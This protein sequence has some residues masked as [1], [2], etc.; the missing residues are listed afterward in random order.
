MSFRPSAWSPRRAAALRFGVE[1]DKAMK[2]RGVGRPRL[3]EHLGMKSHSIIAHWRSGRGLPRIDAAIQL[4]SVLDCPKLVDIVKSVVD[5][6]C[7]TCGKP[8]THTG[9][10]PRRYCSDRCRDIRGKMRAGQPLRQ[11]ADIAEQR[12]A[13]YQIAVNGYCRS[14]EPQGQCREP[15]CPLR[16]VSPLPIIIDL[17]PGRTR[18][19]VQPSRM[20]RPSTLGR[21]VS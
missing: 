21:R 11:R 12:A 17:V 4:A 5:L 13:E 7:E 3:A 18:D 15:E 8:F 1:L 6:K 16:P 20:A 14:C 2:A 19:L 10:G 9:N